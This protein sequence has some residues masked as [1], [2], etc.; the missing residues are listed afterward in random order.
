MTLNLFN[1]CSKDRY[2]ESM[3]FF[4][5][6]KNNMENIQKF[7][8]NEKEVDF[9]FDKKSNVMVN[10]TQMAKIYGKDLFQF[11]KSEGTKSFIKSC[12]K[13]ANAG[14]LCIENEE[15]LITSKQKSG[16]FMHRILALKFAAWLNPDFEFWVYRTIDF[17]LFDYYK[18]LEESL[19]E[20]ARRKNRMDE[21]K[22]KLLE[23][24]EFNELEQ[25]ELQEKQAAYARTKQN[26]YQL[27]IFRST[28]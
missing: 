16:T 19:K 13:P 14:L 22:E 24:P 8:F 2:P 10:A 20:S 7:V 6:T 1:S 5:Y 4:I 9:Q 23:N 17:I 26:R 3:G 25:L 27:D 18:R 12:L 21:L 11:T 15:D 28:Q